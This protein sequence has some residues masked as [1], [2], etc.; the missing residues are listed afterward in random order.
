[1][2]QALALGEKRCGLFKACAQKGGDEAKKLFKLLNFPTFWAS[3]GESVDPGLAKGIDQI[4]R[5]ALTFKRPG[6]QSVRLSPCRDMWSE[7]AKRPFR[8]S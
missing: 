1:M 6:Q 4:A 8:L 5:G 7:V 2:S 3:I